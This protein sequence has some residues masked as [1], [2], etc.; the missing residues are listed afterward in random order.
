MTAFHNKSRRIGVFNNDD[1]IG[2]KV[3]GFKDGNERRELST[4]FGG[5]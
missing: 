4:Y 5:S 2:W 3:V 1:G